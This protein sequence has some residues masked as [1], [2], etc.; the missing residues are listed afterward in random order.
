[1]HNSNRLIA[2]WLLSG[3]ALVFLMVIIG[4]ITRITGSGLSITEWNIVT[5]TIPPLNQNSWIVAFEKYKVS[6][7]FKLVNSGFGLSEFKQIFWWE[8]IHRLLGR[9][10]GFVFLLP[11]LFFLFTKRLTAS[12]LK[13]LLL[14]LALGAL[15]GFLGWFMVKSGLVDLPHVSHYRLAVHLVTAFL[16][17]GFAFYLALGLLSPLPVQSINP[18]PVLPKVTRALLI[19]VILQIMYGAL[20]AGLHAGKV[21]TTFPKMGDRWVPREI[22]A[23]QPFYR[24]LSENL[25]TVQFI[26]RCLAWLIG[27]I[28]FSLCAIGVKQKERFTQKQIKALN[29]LFA[30]FLFQ[31]LLGVF[32][33]LSAVSVPLAILHQAGAFFL[34]AGILYF[35]HSQRLSSESIG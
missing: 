23:I 22:N 28:I 8:Y 5:G 1:M 32:T 35:S 33:L 31:F 2:G 14:L 10:I 18:L 27:I 34:F 24:N 25:V 29:L 17:F 19:L 9:L 4:G 7:Q 30:L 11:F 12:L 26:H 3:C 20:V 21:Y 15:Q 13:K 16:I 6:P